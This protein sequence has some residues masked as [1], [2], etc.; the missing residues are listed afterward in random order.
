MH[1][2]KPSIQYQNSYHQYIQELGDEERYPFPLD[3][4]YEDFPNL[5]KRLDEIELGI[6]LPDGYVASSTYWLIN[7]DEILGVSNLRHTL[8]EKIE[9]MGGH[10]GLGIRPSLR[11]HGFG[12]RL[13]E[14]TLAEARKKGITCAH[15]HCEKENIASAR[16]IQ[17][18]GGFLHSEVTGEAHPSVVQRYR[19]NLIF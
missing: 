5:I 13:M 3:F 11:N 7:E 4:P 14:L 6:N 19:V 10:V 12:R 15:I 17:A 16:L 9:F 18:V 1:L 8:N 2:V